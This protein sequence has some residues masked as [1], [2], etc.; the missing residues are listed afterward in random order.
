M[1]LGL[2]LW[3]AL[4]AHVNP[5]GAWRDEELDDLFVRRDQLPGPAD[6]V[7]PH[8]PIVQVFGPEGVGKTSLLIATCNLARRRGWRVR[9]RYVAP[10]QRLRW[11]MPVGYELICVDEAQRLA[12]PLLKLLVTAIRGGCLRWL[13]LGTHRCLSDELGL[14]AQQVQLKPWSA[15]ELAE[16]YERRLRW[17]G[18]DPN[19]FPLT[20]QA[21]QLVDRQAA[22]SCR[23][24]FSLLY[25]VF[26]L[27]L[28]HVPGSL[29]PELILAVA[30]RF[31]RSPSAAP[32]GLSTW[33][34][35]T[36]HH[37]G[38][39]QPDPIASVDRPGRPSYGPTRR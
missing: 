10:G 8:Q 14:P 18:I 34:T 20:D 35:A 16:G 29:E 28:P 19:R 17:A 2:R 4:G 15:P 39:S 30:P 38:S 3:Q 12:T 22:G 11:L 31:T 21:L 33:G 5:F 26:Q 36:A 7:H 25:D 6:L 32:S 37:V 13:V 1:A 24:A 9:Y 27:R 23:E